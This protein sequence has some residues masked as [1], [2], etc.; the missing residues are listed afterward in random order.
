MY[1]PLRSVKTRLREKRTTNLATLI[2]G[3][4]SDQ[5]GF[6]FFMEPRHARLIRKKEAER[7]TLREFRSGLSGHALGIMV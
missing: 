3:S 6:Q 5:G 1:L 2:L 7:A 4:L